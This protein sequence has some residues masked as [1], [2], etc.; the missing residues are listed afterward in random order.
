MLIQAVKI[1]LSTAQTLHYLWKVD[2][3]ALG[4]G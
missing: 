1:V 4:D 2:D 3:I